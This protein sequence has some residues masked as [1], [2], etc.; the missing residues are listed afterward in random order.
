MVSR[1]FVTLGLGDA[2]ERPA[3]E[4]IAALDALVDDGEP[5]LS[6]YATRQ[7]GPWVLDVL[8]ATSDAD[9]RARWLRAAAELVPAMADHQID[10]VAERDW[11]AESQRAL[12]PVRAGRFVV[13]GS[14]DAARLPPSR[15]RIKIDAGRAFGT[16]H[17]ASTVGCLL[18]LE[19]LARRAPLGRVMDV[20]TGTGLLAIAADRLGAAHVVAGDVDPVAVAVARANAARNATRRPIRCVEASGPFA[21]ADTVLANILARPLI[22]MA[23]P[24]RRA[25]GRTLVLSGLRAR[26]RRR[27]AAAYLSRGFVLERVL[28]V[29]DW[30]TLIMVAPRPRAGRYAPT[31]VRL[32]ASP[33]LGW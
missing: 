24:M 1:A 19:R 23:S 4:A 25:T 2:Y 11:V 33:N 10:D 15:W 16:A 30:A 12:H 17:H 29:E 18:A 9:Q 8:F 20:G 26:E 28:M 14:H 32:G 21:R 22:A 7:D 5:I 13:H 6:A 31:G 3:L 27:V